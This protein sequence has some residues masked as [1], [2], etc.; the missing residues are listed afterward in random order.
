MGLGAC[1]TWLVAAALFR[2]SSLAALIA[3]AAAP[4][5]AWLYYG[6][7]QLLQFCAFLAVLAWVRHRTNIAR[8]LRG[9]EPRIGR[10][11]R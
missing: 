3:L 5:Y 9:E 7:L 1:A 2:I 8:L 11:K 4:L 10:S 6:D